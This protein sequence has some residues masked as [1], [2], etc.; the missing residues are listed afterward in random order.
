MTM[1]EKKLV[2]GSVTMVALEQQQLKKFSTTVRR[3]IETVKRNSEK[4]QRN[5]EIARKY[6]AR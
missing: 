1:P 2:L 6:V 3:S 4:A 5:V